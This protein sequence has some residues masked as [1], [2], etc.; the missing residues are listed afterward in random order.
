MKM[1][2]FRYTLFRS[3]RFY[4]RCMVGARQE[5][6]PN[7]SCPELTPLPPKTNI[8]IYIKENIGW[9]LRLGL[10]YMINTRVL[11]VKIVKNIQSP[12]TCR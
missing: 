4:F 10:T 5:R 12:E 6:A 7:F 11:N 9:S 3:P 2:Y 8:Y 1:Q